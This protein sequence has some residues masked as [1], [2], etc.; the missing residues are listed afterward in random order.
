MGGTHGLTGDDL[1]GYGSFRGGR[2][3]HGHGVGV[4][5]GLLG[6]RLLVGRLEP[7]EHIGG[8]CCCWGLFAFLLFRQWE[9]WEMA[10]ADLS[11]SQTGR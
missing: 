4:P 7:V 10:E 1:L 9:S 3:L 5:G 2:L 6:S 8:G 11:R